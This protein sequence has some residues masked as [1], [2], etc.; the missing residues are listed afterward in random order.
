M[1]HR[2]RAGDIRTVAVSIKTDHTAVGCIE[3][4][5]TGI[6]NVD[7]GTTAAGHLHTK[8]TALIGV[9]KTGIAVRENTVGNINIRLGENEKHTTQIAVVSGKC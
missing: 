4:V 7:I 2:D 1:I 6:G 8:Y 3:I 5:K 9:G